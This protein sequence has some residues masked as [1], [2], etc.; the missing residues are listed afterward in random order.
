MT[1]S[2]LVT[3]K[4]P[5]TEH[6]QKNRKIRDKIQENK[7]LL[8]STGAGVDFLV[9]VGDIDGLFVGLSVCSEKKTKSKKFTSEPRN[10]MLEKD[11]IFHSWVQNF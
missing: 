10:V 2:P 11:S 7:K 4:P 6:T 8:P 1:I 5:Q 9:C 3:S